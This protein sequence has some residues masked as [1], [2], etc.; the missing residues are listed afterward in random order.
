MVLG[1]LVKIAQITYG[2]GFD[3]LPAL[4]LTRT[5]G[6]SKSRLLNLAASMG[7]PGSRPP[8]PAPRSV[9]PL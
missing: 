6:A 2:I 4:P 9:R 3:I 8:Q 5:V 1:D 7:S